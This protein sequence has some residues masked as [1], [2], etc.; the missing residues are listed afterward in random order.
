MPDHRPDGGPLAR[1]TLWLVGLFFG[2]GGS[3]TGVLME[4]LAVGLADRGYR[5]EAVAGR[6]EYGT[7]VGRGEGR[8]TGRVR[9]LFSGPRKPAGLFGRLFSWAAFYAAAAA[10]AFTRRLPAVVVVNTTPP[11]LHAVFVLRRLVTRSRCRLV[12]WNQDT[13]PEIL[14]AVGLLRPRGLPYRGVMAVERWAT[15]RTDRVVALDGA[16]A[17]LMGRHGAA[18]VRVIP[19]WDV[20]HAAPVAPPNELDAAVAA[21]RKQYRFVLVYTGNY[22]WGHDLRPLF[23]WL[24]AN[25][26]QRDFFPLFNG[27]GEKWAEVAALAAELGPWRMAVF[28]Y[29]PRERVPRLIAAGDFGLVTLE[30]GCAGLMSPS[31]IHGYLAAGKPLIYLGPPGSNV[32]EAIDRFGCGVRIGYG[33]HDAL[34]AAL[35]RLAGPDFDY[36]GM[37]AAAR[38]ASVRHTETAAAEAFDSLLR[39]LVDHAR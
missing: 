8:F 3:P 10:F 21:A 1:P 14:A 22:G 4:S 34:P 37:A 16:M 39:E 36:A 30:D 33:D 29:G 24:R 19:N 15:R 32:A 9:R 27:G 6:S 13:Y 17:D 35:A 38:A 18:G 28:P 12:L 20:P 2:G 31:K 11:L 25:P 26:D 7:G 5:V 23:A